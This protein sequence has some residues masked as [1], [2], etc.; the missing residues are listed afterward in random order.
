MSSFIPIYFLTLVSP[1]SIRR[2][3]LSLLPKATYFT[4]V[5]RDPDLPYWD[6]PEPPFEWFM[7][8]LLSYKAKDY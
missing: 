3:C 8:E 2:P 4:S 5:S 1:A 7:D 6:G